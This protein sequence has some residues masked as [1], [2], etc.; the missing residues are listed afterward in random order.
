MAHPISSPQPEGFQYLPDFLSPTEAHEV[1]QRIEGLEFE[2]VRMHGI[3]A[4]RRVLHFGWLYG[5]ESWQLTTGPPG[6]GV[7]HALA[8][9]GGLLNSCA[10]DGAGTGADL[11]IPSRIRNRMAS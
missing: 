9:E 11:A 7:A 4:K 5:Y 1:L 8:R 6:S 10:A 2:A 3:V